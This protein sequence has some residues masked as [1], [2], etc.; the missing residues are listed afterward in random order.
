M[1]QLRDA[2]V[3]HARMAPVTTKETTASRFAHLLLERHLI[4][5]SQLESLLTEDRIA[6]SVSRTPPPVAK[7]GDLGPFG[8]FRLRSEVGRGGMG[9]VYEAHDADLDRR[10]ALK[11]LLSSPNAEAEERELEEER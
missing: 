6:T 9:L 10:V 3:Q 8:K 4:T 11:V 1:D 5:S 7:G 2:L